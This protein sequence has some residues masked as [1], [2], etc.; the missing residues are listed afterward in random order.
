MA[1][2]F[3]EIKSIGF[4]AFLKVY[5]RSF[6][7]QGSFSGK[8]RQ[9]LGFAYCIEPAGNRIWEE[10]EQ[11]KNFYLRHLEYFNANPFMFPLVL[12]AVIKME[13]RFRDDDG[14]RE[15]DIRRFKLA[16]GQA[17]GSVGDRYFWRALRPFAIVLGLL[18]AYFWGL[19]GVTVFL[20]VFNI[21][22]MYLKWRWLL[23]GYRLG[24]R[25]VIEIKNKGLESTVSI[26]EALGSIVLPFLTLIFLA[27]PPYRLS[28]VS[29]GVCL[30]FLFSV[31][32]FHKRQPPSRVLVAS[33]GV[34]VV[35]GM[36]VF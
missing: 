28:W 13:E 14:I 10:A 17:T 30:L 36:I 35:L 32:L 27:H 11:K 33:A 22:I 20:A 15:E 7:A 18:S 29:A 8:Y 6:F 19:W 23:T 3:S 4:P 21:P 9:N 5:L 1:F 16:V 2:L 31:F 12:G 24:P 25:V 26:M 34:A